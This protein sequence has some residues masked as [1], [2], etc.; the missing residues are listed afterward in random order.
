MA[1]TSLYKQ[2]DFCSERKRSLKCWG[3]EKIYNLYLD[4]SFGLDFLYFSAV[5]GLDFLNVFYLCAV[6]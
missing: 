4:F 6:Y 1:A 2:I 5:F 3:K